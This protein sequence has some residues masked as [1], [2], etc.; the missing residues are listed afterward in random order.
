L[1]AAY[2]LAGRYVLSEWVTNL[3]GLVIAL[4]AAWWIQ[5]RAG[6]L[7]EWSIDIPILSA[8]VP[9]IGP[10]VMALT[11]VR[12]F[13]P[14]S[15]VDF[16]LLQGL[17][18]VQVS[19]GCV[20]ASSGLIAPALLGYFV[21]AA[22]AVAAHERHQMMLRS[23][24]GAA[25]RSGVGQI[26]LSTVK[27]SLGTALAGLAFFLASPRSD[28]PEWDPLARFGVKKPQIQPFITGF[29]DSISLLSGGTL[30]QDETP[31]FWVEAETRHGHPI[32]LLTGSTRFRGATLDRYEDGAW[33]SELASWVGARKQI[34]FLDLGE[35]AMVC[36][37]QVPRRA[38]GVF[39]VDPPYLSPGSYG[40]LPIRG[41][42]GGGPQP[43]PFRELGGT[44]V[45]SALLGQ[46]EVRYEQLVL[47]GAIG[48]RWP[49][50]RVE[51]G[52][53]AR[54]ISPPPPGMEKAAREILLRL[55]NGDESIAGPAREL[56][57]EYPPN[58]WLRVGTMLARHLSSSGELAYS[59]DNPAPMPGVDPTLD[60]L[61]RTKRG[62][63]ERFASALCLL[64]RASGIPARIVKGYKGVERTSQGKYVVRQKAAHAWVEM[65]V[66]NGTGL[67]QDWVYLDPTPETEVPPAPLLLRWWAWQQQGGREFWNDL[68]VG[69]NSQQ[70]A[71]IVESL[72][73]GSYFTWAGPALTVVITA[74]T[75]LMLSRLYLKRGMRKAGRG[76]RG[77]YPRL[78]R[79]LKRFGVTP[80]SGELPGEVAARASQALPEP[81]RAIPNEVV[82]VYYKGKY[83]GM[84]S[85]EE[86]SLAS[87]KLETLEAKR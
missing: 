38:G 64:L 12:L 13:R 66:P 16:W 25:P 11:C 55:A 83:G 48:D 10:V 45:G 42:A 2:V 26:V 17:G 20:L 41:A 72:K 86:V 60:F 40:S 65:F 73:S 85:P 29:A 19:L 35:Q 46:P 81:L 27:W 56:P 34:P 53:L 62:A 80:T 63:C 3:L 69:Y 57:I 79:A 7:D 43:L 52:Y 76:L 74:L 23:A 84:A 31:A 59:L 50:V 30:I 71:R 1:A 33:R 15:P 37:F 82:E 70:Q 51:E 49:A 14:R 87:W 39:L 44:V 32:D 68:I 54:L 75:V 61:T 8:I 78:L 58:R 28:Q 22:L 77:L 36:K 47:P 67:S 5:R 18:L 21:V 6:S 4:I 9:Y 24:E